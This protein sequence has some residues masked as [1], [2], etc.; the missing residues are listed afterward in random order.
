MYGNNIT[1]KPT[2]LNE[3]NKKELYAQHV[4]FLALV[5][6]MKFFGGR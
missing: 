4:I 3:N 5:Y 2:E 6:D 1:K